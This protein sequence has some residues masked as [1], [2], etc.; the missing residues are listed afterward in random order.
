M[1]ERKRVLDLEWT[2]VFPNL[3]EHVQSVLG[4]KKNLLLFREMLEA[5]ESPDITLYDNLASGF[6][7]VGKLP[8]SGTLPRVEYEGMLPMEDFLEGREY[9]NTAMLNRL[10]S[11]VI[12]DKEVQDEFDAKSV[13]EIACRKAVEVPLGLALQVGAV[14]PR[15]PI[16]E[17]YKVKGGKR[18]RKVRCI[19]D[20]SA[21]MINAMTSVGEAIR[22]D[23]LDVLVSLYRCLG[24][25]HQRMRFRKDDF[26]GAFKTL[27]LCS[28]QLHLALTAWT[29][30]GGIRAMRLFSAP[31]GAVSSVHSWHRFGAAI[32]RILA[33]LFLIWYPRYVDDL[34]ALDCLQ[35]DTAAN[36]EVTGP[37]G[38]AS[39]ARF[40]VS[41][42]LGW[43][44]D[45]DKAVTNA[46]SCVVLGVTA[47]LD[48]D[49][50]CLVFSLD[51]T[52]LEK[53]L[54]L[55]ES[56]SSARVFSPALS[57]KLAGMLSWGASNIFGRGARVFLA[58]LFHHAA[59]SSWTIPSRLRLALQ[60]W[61]RFLRSRP[62][63]VVPLAPPQRRRSIFYS[64][65]TG[66][67]S[68]AWVAEV[69][70]SLKKWAASTVP[71]SLRRWACRRKVQI[72][73]W[74]LVAA[75]CAL[76]SLLDSISAL[77]ATEVHIFVDSSAALGCLMRGSSRR[78]D[79]N[80]LVQ[81]LWFETARRGILLLGWWVPSALNLAD[82]PTRQAKKRLEM[83][84]LLEAGFTEQQWSWPPEA[85]WL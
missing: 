24:R 6:P 20:F 70:G 84:S 56:L 32:Q 75:V 38:T 50:R 22:H 34:F 39:L 30:A 63:R 85:P 81:H 28:E 9:N 57:R 69:G 14:T 67:G 3:P 16:D 60:W 17:G 78:R 79:W 46:K 66:A 80:A 10:R 77:E 53:F 48:D 62:V 11:S 65:A 55:I 47:T 35:E 40:V 1:V 64:D 26:V 41:E 71:V 44:L 58:P 51:S 43:E 19:D 74:E 15:F 73:T 27:P 59:G 61:S 45:A 8:R 52:K 37:C 83:E 68:I 29:S 7:L 72:A 21:S 13:E 23:S 25:D 5:S 4:P 42:L 2:S 49:E 54:T 82:A 76:W 33:R 12:G 31:F 18:T 36:G